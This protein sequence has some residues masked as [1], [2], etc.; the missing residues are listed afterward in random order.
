MG[1]HTKFN[2]MPISDLPVIEKC[3]N[4]CVL[5]PLKTL[6]NRDNTFNK[7][8]TVDSELHS[9]LSTVSFKYKTYLLVKKALTYMR[10]CY[11]KLYETGIVSST[12]RIH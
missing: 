12:K 4:L 1:L 5:L 11:Q 6:L 7:N 9:V 3:S 10:C 8:N 2:P